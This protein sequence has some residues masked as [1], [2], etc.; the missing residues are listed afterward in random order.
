MPLQEKCS[1]GRCRRSLYSY[2]TRLE[3]ADLLALVEARFHIPLVPVGDRPFSYRPP[4]PRGPEAGSCAHPPGQNSSSSSL[5]A[6]LSL[7]VLDLENPDRGGVNNA[8]TPSFSRR[9][10]WMRDEGDFSRNLGAR[11]YCDQRPTTN[12]AAD[13]QFRT[14][15]VL[16]LKRR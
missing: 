5:S 3:R 7:A 9:L 14:W 4:A 11:Q 13:I 15:H 16:R 8:A 2:T 12:T 1:R 6:D 10:R